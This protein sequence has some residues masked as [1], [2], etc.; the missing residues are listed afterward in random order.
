MK[1]ELQH[2]KSVAFQN[3]SP[4]LKRKL[5]KCQS[6]VNLTFMEPKNDRVTL[7]DIAKR[8]RVSQMTVSRTLKGDERVAPTTRKRIARSSIFWDKSRLARSG[9]FWSL[10]CSRSVPEAGPAS[11]RTSMIQTGCL[12]KAAMMR[13]I[14]SVSGLIMALA[15]SCCNRQTARWERLFIWSMGPALRF[16]QAIIPVSPRRAMRCITSPFWAACRSARWCN[17]SSLNMPGRLRQSLASRI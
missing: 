1:K 17:I 7:S 4:S 9:G 5:T 2:K 14:I 12:R 11:R 15:C 10:S 16:R 6:N 3:K 8:C 13:S